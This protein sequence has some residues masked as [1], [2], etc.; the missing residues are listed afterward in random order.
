[1]PPRIRR[2]Y[3]P[4]KP[5]VHTSRNKSGDLGMV[6]KKKSTLRKHKRTT[7]STSPRS[8]MPA[9]TLQAKKQ[10]ETAL[11]LE[12]FPASRIS[13]ERVLP[14]LPRGKEDYGKPVVKKLSYWERAGLLTTARTRLSARKEGPIQAKNRQP[15]RREVKPG[16]NMSSA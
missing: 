16:K 8:C 12:T 6:A 3:R 7:S 5:S 14:D 9:E 13:S 15:R 4:G 2:A 11:I 1:M 10:L